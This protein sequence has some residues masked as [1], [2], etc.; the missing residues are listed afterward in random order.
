MQ[1]RKLVPFLTVIIV[2]VG[3]SWWAAPVTADV[4]KLKTLISGQG[5]IG[6]HDGA[7]HFSLDGGVTFA[8]AFIIA[9]HPAYGGPLAGTNWINF[10]PTFASGPVGP[11]QLTIYRTHFDLPATF[12]APSLTVTLLADNGASIVLNGNLVGGQPLGGCPFACPGANFTVPSAFADANAAHFQKGR[13]VLEFH[14][15][16]FGGAAGFNYLATIMYTVDG[17]GSS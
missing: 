5:A 11:L 3:L 12:A 4:T 15:T 6:G 10:A 17:K 8:P 7:N 2:V 14:H 9:K 16:D 1:N 13:N